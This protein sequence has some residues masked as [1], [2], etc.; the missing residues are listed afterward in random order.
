MAKIIVSLTDRKLYVYLSNSLYG[1]YP[2]AIGKASTP[3]PLGEFKVIEKSINPG[4]ALGTRW[5]GFTRER[6]GIHGNNNPSSIGS[7]ASLGCVRMYNHDVE[8]IYPHIP[9]GSPIIV[10]EY[11]TDNNG[12]SYHSPTNS[13]NNPNHSKSYNS[14]NEKVY[15][16][17]SGDSL[18]KIS[19]RF[20][21]SLNQLKSIN[22][23]TSDLIY[24]GQTLNIPN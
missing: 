21:V 7:A 11:F 9:M 19:Q 1:V 4:G 15:T 14:G 13:P 22:N 20:S 12:V 6:H 3:T 24:P 17:M 18:W 8:A 2:V 16:V 5:I 23:L 10:K